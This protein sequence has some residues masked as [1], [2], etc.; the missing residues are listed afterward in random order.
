MFQHK[1]QETCDL[2]ELQSTERTPSMGEHMPDD[3]NYVIFKV[4]DIVFCEYCVET[5]VIIPY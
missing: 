3:G 2:R 4:R 5:E 1:S